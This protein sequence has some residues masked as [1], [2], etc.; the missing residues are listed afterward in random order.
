[1]EEKKCKRPGLSTSIRRRIF[2]RD[3]ATCQKCGRRDHLNIHHIQAVQDGGK[4]EDN[5]LITLCVPCHR[6]WELIEMVTSIPFDMW[7]PMPTYSV[8]LTTFLLQRKEGTI[9]YVNDWNELIMESH[10]YACIAR[11]QRFLGV[12][13][14]E[15]EQTA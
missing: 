13:V 9:M 15:E 7:L 5:N 12:K 11:S 1:M 14:E 10:H 6:E 4:D 8:L 2:T 3:E